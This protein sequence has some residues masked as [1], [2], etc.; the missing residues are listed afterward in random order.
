M[1]K[2]IREIIF[3]YKTEVSSL[4]EKGFFI[5]TCHNDRNNYY[6]GRF[7]RDIIQVGTET[8]DNSFTG[9]TSNSYDAWKDYMTTNKG[10]V[11]TNETF[12]EYEYDVALLTSSHSTQNIVEETI[13]ALD[14]IKPKK[15]R[16]SDIFKRKV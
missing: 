16:I 7:E 14:I 5:E 11:F 4:E 9:F 13:K 10:W 6:I 3:T 12:I 8:I 15:K 2:I 1:K